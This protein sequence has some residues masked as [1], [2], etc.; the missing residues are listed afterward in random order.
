[1]DGRPSSAA[2]VNWMVLDQVKVRTCL[3]D[4]ESSAGPWDQ[5][6]VKGDRANSGTWADQDRSRLPICW[7]GGHGLLARDQA[8]ASRRMPATTLNQLG[9]WSGRTR[10]QESRKGGCQ[11]QVRKETLLD[12]PNP[13]GSQ[14]EAS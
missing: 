3:M 2:A 4:R 13:A 14:P 7:L 8:L 5:H 12:G 11:P 6:L 10:Q 1:M 9:G